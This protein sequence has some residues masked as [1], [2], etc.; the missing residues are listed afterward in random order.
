MIPTITKLFNLILST[1]K[2]PEGW[3][4]GL[5]KPIFKQKGSANDPN[6]YRGITII[7]CFAKLFTSALNERL[8][9]YFND[10][11]TIGPEQAGFRAGFSA[12]DHV[13]VLHSIIDFFLAKGKRLYCLFVDY[14]KAFDYVDRV[15]L[16]QKLINA[17]VNGRILRV[18]QNIYDKAKACVTVGEE[19][20][21]HFECSRGIRQGI[22]LSPLLFAI[23]LND[24][25]RFL[26]RRVE[27]LSSLALEAPD[28]QTVST[29]LKMFILLYADDTVICSE[30]PEGLQR[31]VDEL[32]AYCRRWA[33][34]I[35]VSKTKA[36]VFS[37]GKVRKLPKLVCNNT[38]IEFVYGFNYLGVWF[39]YNNKFAIAQKQQYNKA[40]RAMFSLIKKM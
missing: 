28:R 4:I 27:G 21:E 19:F 20:S 7:S 18:I 39:N 8:V 26:S 3:S 10:C 22:N 14:E 1:G 5:I 12:M 17:N 25:Q 32:S 35:N 40:S 31:S 24:L 29:L 6:N 36:I 38:D 34:R 9:K 16:W 11:S 33:L 30:T 13:F 2:I 23:Y 37:R 15:F